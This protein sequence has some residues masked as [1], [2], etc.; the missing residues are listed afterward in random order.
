MIVAALVMG[1]ATQKRPAPVKPQNETL[2]EAS[3]S[4]SDNTKI[5]EEP[6]ES[7]EPSSENNEE[8]NN[9]AKPEIN[10]SVSDNDNEASVSSNNNEEILDNTDEDDI[11]PPAIDPLPDDETG[12][13]SNG[14]TVEIKVISGDSSVSVSR[15]L[16]EAGL[17]ESAVEFD[18]FLCENHYDKFICVGT[19]DIEVGSDFETMAKIITRRNY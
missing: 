15:R 6:V 3:I 1:V 10:V 13:T 2:K 11:T 16:F 12:F 14:E 8:N 5:D 17:V 7:V 19:Y 9:E 4:V 18:S